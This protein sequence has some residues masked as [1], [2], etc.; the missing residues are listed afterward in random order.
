MK[1][2]E[3]QQPITLQKLYHALPAIIL[4]GIVFALTGVLG[5]FLTNT[6]QAFRWIWLP[7][8]IV[9]GVVLI[10]DYRYLASI[11]PGTLLMAFL[12]N[13]MPLAFLV[14]A[15]SL[16]ISTGISAY[17]LKEVIQIKNDLRSIRDVVALMLGVAFI[18]AL[19]GATPAAFLLDIFNL[20]VSDQPFILLWLCDAIDAMIG[21]VAF[22]PVVLLWTTR[23]PINYSRFKIL[24]AMLLIG[25]TT[26]TAW[27]AYSNV[28][29]FESYF[30]ILYLLLPTSLWA[31]LRFHKREVVLINL[32]VS[33]FSISSATHASPLLP[34]TFTNLT[35]TEYLFFVWTSTTIG[36]VVSL[37]V[38]CIVDANNFNEQ[39]LAEE[40]D[41]AIQMM[42]RLGQGVTVLGANGE[43][44]YVNDT[45]AE[46]VK[47]KVED[48]VGKSP[49]E[50]VAESFHP[51]LEK[52]MKMRKD[53]ASST[54]EAILKASDGTLVPVMVTGSP[55]QQGENGSIS[56]LK[57]LRPLQEAEHA[58]QQSEEQFRR[59]FENTQVGMYRSHPDGRLI[60]INPM[61]AQIAD[62]ASPEE[63]MKHVHSSPNEPGSIYVDSDRKAEF[64]RLL[65]ETGRVSDLESE[66]ITSVSNR[67]IWIK[68]NAQMVYDE[69]GNKLYYEG[70]VQD[71][72]QRK[73]NEEEL[74]RSEMLFRT[75]FENTADG[76]VVVDR[77]E[78]IIRC[79]R[80]FQQM[81]GYEARDLIDQPYL[82]FV[83][84]DS[85]DAEKH[86]LLTTLA[87]NKDNFQTSLMYNRKD[88]T[89]LWT[90]ASVGL[91]RN[92]DGEFQYAIGVNRD[93]TARLEAQQVLEK[94]EKQFRAI[95]ENA[96]L[97]IAV[98]RN[99]R[100]IAMANPAFCDMLGYTQEE[101]VQLRFDDVTYPGDND[102]NVEKYQQL[103][104]GEI[105][106][107][108][109]TKRYRHRDGQ[110]VWAHLSVSRFDGEVVGQTRD[111]VYTIAIAENITERKFAED[112]LL[113]QMRFTDKIIDAL[114][115]VFYLFDQNGKFLRWNKSMEVVTGYTSQEFSDLH[116]I[117]FFRPQDQARVTEAI[118]TVF[119][120]GY[121]IAELDMLHRDGTITPHLLNGYRI[122]LND[123]P[124]VVGIGIDVSMVKMT[125][126][127]L[128]QSEERYRSMFENA[129]FGIFRST[130]DGRFLS[131]NPALVEILG[132]DSVDELYQLDLGKDVHL[133]TKHR[134]SL[135]DNLNQ[136]D[137]IEEQHVT[138]R[139]KNG[140]LIIASVK[141]K[142]VRDENGDIQ[143]Y[144]GN[145]TDVTE[146]FRQAEKIQQLN[147]DLEQRVIERT[148]QLASANDRL[149]ELDRLKSK[150]I[151][152]VSHELRT[153]L[154]VLNTRLYLLEHGKD[155]L[156]KHIMGFR[157][158]LD[159]LQEFVE[160]VFD[161][162]VIDLSR[163]NVEF[164][165]VS[166]NQIVEQTIIA[167]APRA[168]VNDIALE[169]APD[170]TLPPIRGVRNHLLQVATNIIANALKY[171]ENGTVSI[172]TGMD[173]S[174]Q[175]VYLRVKDSGMGIAPEDVPH[176]F[177]RFYRGEQTGQSNIP[178][179]GLG[180]AI[181]K[182]ILESHR[183]DIHIE[184]KVGEGS[185]FTVWL[186]V[187]RNATLAPQGEDLSTTLE[188]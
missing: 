106:N 115:G 155:N 109:L 94:S 177:E 137:I 179:T 26:L 131:V 172:H 110:P 8:G 160:N 99:D 151:A 75:I 25:T 16:T 21:I 162:S 186:P 171:T 89:I 150:F 132:Y 59:I 87:D 184:S 36:G 93:I 126:I 133:S 161:L 14:V 130:P 22:T 187:E 120:D 185:T 11:I 113:S 53:G 178:G 65:H 154:A 61:F 111:H 88:G 169:F 81:L 80:A 46:I 23:Q 37:M 9:L 182:E 152:D 138:L 43:Y 90:Q 104:I 19:I 63:F 176:L 50:F 129:L 83:H 40:R 62:C 31:I 17:L 119:R 118:E 38:K 3:Q 82:N 2:V 67:R 56:V 86:L 168:E 24:E 125:E 78:N 76:I 1:Q 77:S 41:F 28:L 47:S 112:Q 144:E 181:V 45:F 73:I 101:L 27:L 108:T 121:D 127:A 57:D 146:R 105:D 58:R 34:T 95:F 48:I 148:H 103:T 117:D 6:G 70:T 10:K 157:M 69:D 18:H 20:R 142:A 167:L 42:G 188:E 180:L 66:V 91:I 97:P 29:P 64:L 49:Y 5:A 139:K 68:E 183:G 92:A 128:K 122:T 123:M 145:L 102:E 39:R 4:L 84:P 13:Q 141:A 32:I 30:P 60:T 140:D 12:T 71:I 85:R 96:S 51:E 44:E 114:P 33:L 175:Q 134:D 149:K 100:H 74:R 143:Y 54:Y 156:E 147:E 116:P 55:R 173:V 165:S 72:T 98:T 124:C 107:F 163:D 7:G 35:L 15:L 170:E 164:Q 159:R 158:Q 79:N 136:N 166:L 153:P 135:G 52:I 174:R